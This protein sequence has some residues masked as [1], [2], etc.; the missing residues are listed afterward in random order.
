MVSLSLA[1]VTACTRSSRIHSGSL[2]GTNPVRQRRT[3]TQTKKNRR[4]A[5]WAP[6][7]GRRMH[8]RIPKPLAREEK[9]S[10]KA[11]RMHPHRKAAR[12]RTHH[13]VCRKAWAFR[14]MVK[15]L[16]PNALLN[17]WI[18]VD[19]LRCAPS[20]HGGML[21]QC[22]AHPLVNSMSTGSKACTHECADLPLWSPT[23]VLSGSTGHNHAPHYAGLPHYNII[24]HACAVKSL[25]PQSVARM[26]NP[27]PDS[28]RK[29][30]MPN[31]SPSLLRNGCRMGVPT[32]LFS[33]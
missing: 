12:M 19:I 11:H 17:V 14:V 28:M 30:E 26:T 8:G 3:Q 16:Q 24:K 9:H 1:N 20:G 31:G 32:P 5:A 18:S 4:D 29:W 13:T 33:P 2:R 25:S 10:D 15:W 21:R 23:W 7:G 27:P 22:G 6:C